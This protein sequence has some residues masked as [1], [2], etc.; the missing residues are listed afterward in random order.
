MNFKDKALVGGLTYKVILDLLV[1]IGLL[2]SNLD[3]FKLFLLLNFIIKISIDLF[4][5]RRIYNISKNKESE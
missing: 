5:I 4:A 3:P 2:M 1:V